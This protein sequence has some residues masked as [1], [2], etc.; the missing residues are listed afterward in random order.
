MMKLEGLRVDDEVILHFPRGYRVGEVRKVVWAGKLHFKIAGTDAKY[1][2]SDGYE[3]S[4]Y[5]HNRPWCGPA[6]EKGRAGLVEHAARLARE[7][8]VETFRTVTS[9][10]VVTEENEAECRA[11]AAR[12]EEMKAEYKAKCDAESERW[13]L[14]REA[15]EAAWAKRA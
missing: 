7:R 8:F 4:E 14:K 5:S 9:G 11:I 6:D 1:R 3:L 12:L 10:F 15:D 13:R 2:R